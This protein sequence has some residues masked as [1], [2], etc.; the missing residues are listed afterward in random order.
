MPYKTNSDGTV[1][2]GPLAIANITYNKEAVL[3]SPVRFTEPP[4]GAVITE[5]PITVKGEGKPGSRV[6]VYSKKWLGMRQDKPVR[7]QVPE[8]GV[9]E[10]TI[11]RPHARSA[12][13]LYAREVSLDDRGRVENSGKRASVSFKVNLPYDQR[14]SRQK[15][16]SKDP[17]ASS[18]SSSSDSSD[19]SD[20]GSDSSSSS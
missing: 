12:Y 9:W 6:E 14:S 19:S 8:S 16:R 3:N 2:E 1:V 4:A 17:D 15:L 5:N 18:G 20:S 13:T 7:I 11:S 10:H